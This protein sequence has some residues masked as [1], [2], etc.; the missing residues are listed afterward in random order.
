[1]CF[2]QWKLWILITKETYKFVVFCGMNF[3]FKRNLQVCCALCIE[4]L[5]LKKLTSLLC[6]VECRE[7][8]EFWETCI[9]QLSRNR[10]NVPDNPIPI[11]DFPISKFPRFRCRNFARFGFVFRGESDEPRPTLLPENWSRLSSKTKLFLVFETT[12]LVLWL[13]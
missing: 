7:F 5:L 3:N 13:L 9:E 2:V 12:C 8:S 10:H 11:S 6:F 4:I 1:M